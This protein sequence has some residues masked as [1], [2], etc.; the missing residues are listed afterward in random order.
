MPRPA[1]FIVVDANAPVVD[2]ARSTVGDVG[3]DREADLDHL[4]LG[5]VADALGTE[6]LDVL[7]S[8][9][10][11]GVRRRAAVRCVT[12]AS[13][14]HRVVVGLGVEVRPP[15]GRRWAVLLRRHLPLFGD[16]GRESRPDLDA[17][18]VAF[19][20]KA[21]SV[22]GGEVGHGHHVRAVDLRHRLGHEDHR[23]AGG[24][25]GGMVLACKLE[26]R[27]Q[28]VLDAPQD[29]ACAVGGLA[30]RDVLEHALHLVQP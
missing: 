28:G 11:G 25:R 9:E 23:Y 18:E 14:W 4:L 12:E 26:L 20:V 27:L 7:A 5:P 6:Q 30:A 3:A 13:A 24:V 21:L 29:S 8:L 2:G 16:G 19:G 10:E 22:G 15:H 1:M 17:E